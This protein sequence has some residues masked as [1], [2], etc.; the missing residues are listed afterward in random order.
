VQ[1][2]RATE[3]F[4]ANQLHLDEHTATAEALPPASPPPRPQVDWQAKYETLVTSLGAVL[5]AA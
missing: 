4:T 5:K 2:Q 3:R 1:V